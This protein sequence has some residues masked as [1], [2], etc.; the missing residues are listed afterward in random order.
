MKSCRLDRSKSSRK[1]V[2]SSEADVL[3][4]VEIVPP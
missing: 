4:G 3:Q 2:E 1:V